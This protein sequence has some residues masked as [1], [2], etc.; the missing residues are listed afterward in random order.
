MTNNNKLC[1]NLR[2]VRKD[3][4]RKHLTMKELG[5]MIGM[6][7]P[8]T[9]SFYFRNP[10]RIRLNHVTAIAAA[11]GSTP[12]QYDEYVVRVRNSEEYDKLVNGED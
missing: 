12:Y 1:L 5:S 11:L 4:R 10:D 2:K 3:M 6:K 7:D 8:H 9:I